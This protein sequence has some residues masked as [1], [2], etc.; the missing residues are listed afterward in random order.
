MQKTPKPVDVEVG[1]RIRFRRLQ[2]G[3]SQEKLGDRVGL[4]F[5]QIQ[6]YEKGGNR[7]SASRLQEIADAL[8]T[9][10]SY[11]FRQ[12]ADGAGAKLEFVPFMMTDARGLEVVDAWPKLTPAMRSILAGVIVAVANITKA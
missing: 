2:M 9:P 11:F 3:I 12:T 1:K 7:V 10:A 6:K 8:E 5:Q 4:T